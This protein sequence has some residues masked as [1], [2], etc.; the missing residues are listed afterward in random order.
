[1]TKSTN[2][3]LSHGKHWLVYNVVN[4][5]EVVVYTIYYGVLLISWAIVMAIAFPVLSKVIK[6]DWEK[7]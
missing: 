7:E 2:F 3:Y 6:H 5:V 1:M 4:P